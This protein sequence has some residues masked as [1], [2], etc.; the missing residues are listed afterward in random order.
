MKLTF[1]IQLRGI[2]KPPVWRKMEIPGNFTFD[3]FHKAIQMAFGW[4]NCHLYQFQRN[5]Y[6]GGWSIALPSEEAGFGFDPD[7]IDARATLVGD[8][9][10]EQGLKKFVYVYDFGDDWIHDIMLEEMDESTN[11]LLPFCLEGKGAC[12]PED[13]GGIPGY[14][15]LK[16]LL[17]TKPGSSEAKMLLNWLGLEKSDDFDP[18]YFDR[19]E[20]NLNM[21]TLTPS[22]PKNQP[23]PKNN[24]RAEII[25]MHPNHTLDMEELVKQFMDIFGN[26]KSE[27]YLD[28][29]HLEDYLAQNFKGIYCIDEK[30]KRYEVK[31]ERS[32]K[33]CVLQVPSVMTLTGFAQLLMKIFGYD[34]E[35][36]EFVDLDNYSFMSAKEYE[37]RDKSRPADETGYVTIAN[38][39][40]EADDQGHF[41]IKKNGRTAASFK[42]TLRKSGRYTDKTSASHIKLLSSKAIDAAAT[43]LV[44]QQFASDNPLPEESPA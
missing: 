16:M 27:N 19:G 3:D 38:L 23:K 2:T 17:S 1:R 18:K 39:L 33:V 5:A 13:C 7:S 10:K 12:P 37:N 8:F 44:V 32:G 22:K 29:D 9:I 26:T 42:L 28:D 6:D 14:E 24:G 36:Y 31:V 34:E 20:V 4:E 25:E 35:Y 41:K 11:Q 43:E 15:H 21:T 40:W 30:C